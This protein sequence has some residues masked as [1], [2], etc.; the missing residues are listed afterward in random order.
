MVLQ[1]FTLTGNIL[2]MSKS[3]NYQVPDRINC[4]T[5]VR[6]CK[7]RQKDTK[8]MTFTGT[9]STNFFIPEYLGLGKSVSRGFGAVGG[10]Q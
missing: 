5:D 1:T 9:F 2:S 6:I 3:L 4:E 10:R 7:G 8:I